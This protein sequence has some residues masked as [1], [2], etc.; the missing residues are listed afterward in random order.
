M[1]RKIGS[2]FQKEVLTLGFTADKNPFIVFLKKMKDKSSFISALKQKPSAYSCIH[3]A[4]VDK[5]I[6]A[7][8]LCQTG[9]ARE[10]NI[11]FS[12]FLY[13]KPIADIQKYLV[14]QATVLHLF[15]DTAGAP[16]FIDYLPADKE[17]HPAPTLLKEKYNK[18]PEE[19]ITDLFYQKG[20]VLAGKV[21][22][23]AGTLTNDL[24]AVD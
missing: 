6:S 22:R 18:K 15:N 17:A 7:D 12:P 2:P 21:A 20:N 8:D 10:A 9:I 14:I 1:L 23:E 19:F 13:N 4:Y 24:Y 5:L 3:N 16:K 11:I